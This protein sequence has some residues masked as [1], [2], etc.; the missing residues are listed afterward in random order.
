M[1]LLGLGSNLQNPILHLK[2]ALHFFPHFQLRIRRISSVYQ[3]KP[4]GF[5]DQPPFYNL[6][7]EIQ[8]PLPPLPLLELLQLIEA[9]LGRQRS[10]RWGPRV[11]DID[12][13]LY[14]SWHI[15]TPRLQIPHPYLLER[16][17]YLIPILEL[18]PDVLHP[19]TGTPLSQSPAANDKDSILDILPFTALFSAGADC[20]Y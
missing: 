11:I 10:F 15:Q 6:V 4:W 7:V 12:I 9:T 8:T 3:T 2:K 18:Y 16:P 1:I 5:L 17:F 20:E 19:V 13:L 14:H